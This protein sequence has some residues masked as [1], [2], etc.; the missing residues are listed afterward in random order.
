MSTVRILDNGIEADDL[1]ELADTVREHGNPNW[2]KQTVTDLLEQSSYYVGIQS[3]ENLVAFGC[4]RESS[5]GAF[6]L[7]NVWEKSGCVDEESSVAVVDH[8]LEFL[9]KK[10]PVR[11]CIADRSAIR[12]FMRRFSNSIT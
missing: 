7:R 1:C 8:L 5:G 4:L 11:A 3:N 2:N 10:R 6:L 9:R 12:G